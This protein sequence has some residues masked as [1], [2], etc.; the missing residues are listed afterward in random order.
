MAVAIDLDMVSNTGAIDG[1]S[2]YGVHLSLDPGDRP[3]IRGKASAGEVSLS[4][5]GESGWHTLLL[6]LGLLRKA[7]PAE[8]EGGVDSQKVAPQ[9]LEVDSTFDPATSDCSSCASAGSHAFGDPMQ[10]LNAAQYRRGFP[11][12]SET[13]NHI[14]GGSSE[15]PKRSL[16]RGLEAY[17]GAK[18]RESKLERRRQMHKLELSIGITQ[19]ATHMRPT[20]TIELPQPLGPSSEAE[21]TV[22]PRNQVH[23]RPIGEQC[24]LLTTNADCPKQ[25]RGELPR[26]Q[27]FL[28]VSKVTASPAVHQAAD[29]DRTASQADTPV[30]KPDNQAG[31]PMTAS[32]QR[33]GGERSELVNK[34]DGLNAPHAQSMA[35]AFVLHSSSAPSIPPAR[36][37]V[38]SSNT[39]QSNAIA[40]SEVSAAVPTSGL[41]QRFVPVTCSDGPR[42]IQQFSNLNR[43]EVH[44]ELSRFPD[45]S[46]NHSQQQWIHSG[47][48][49]AEAGFQD[50]SLGWVSVRAERDGTG[51]HAVLVAP[52]HDAGRTL[53][54]HLSGLN[55]HLADHQI[56]VSPVTMSATRDNRIDSGIGGG[57]Q[58]D[59]SDSRGHESG[60]QPR[61]HEGRRAAGMSSTGAVRSLNSEN[62][63]EAAS[64]R[65]G[66]NSLNGV[67]VSLV[68]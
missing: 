60:E 53:S 35:S 64:L 28:Q 40:A 31:A 66:T 55:A 49:F 22:L 36:S 26:E 51:M 52:S 32:A 41:P 7:D 6:Q 45:Q 18:D 17:R 10:E 8:L 14:S 20:G 30:G 16:K 47:L 58:R 23:P 42:D 63:N 29:E 38:R 9:K 61:S 48:R 67:H 12:S 43:T 13:V 37:H 15:L 21:W 2:R 68:A 39:Q 59:T 27:E 62:R 33:A 56:Q 5:N 1:I 44:D 11:N 54:A 57:S 3:V 46:P 34:N 50:P 4:D 65:T 19:P 25:I 24:D